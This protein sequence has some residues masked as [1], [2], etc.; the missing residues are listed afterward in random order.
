MPPILGQS[1]VCKLMESPKGDNGYKGQAIRLMPY[2]ELISKDAA[3]VCERRKDPGT[4]SGTCA[5]KSGRTNN[6]R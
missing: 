1:M 2:E 5:S 3:R 6:V 4:V